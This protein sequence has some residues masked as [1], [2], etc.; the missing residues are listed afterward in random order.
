MSKVFELPIGCK[1]VWIRRLMDAHSPAFIGGHYATWSECAEAILNDKERRLF[2]PYA[3]WPIILLPDGSE[4]EI[5]DS[6]V[7]M[8]TAC[9]PASGESKSVFLVVMNVRYDYD[10]EVSGVLGAYSTQSAANQFVEE[11]RENWE[12]FKEHW[13]EETNRWGRRFYLSGGPQGFGGV[14]VENEVVR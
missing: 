12:H 14:T 4:K 8:R 3:P 13:H 2:G 5:E 1:L 11:L 7:R 6:F 9:D 10:Q